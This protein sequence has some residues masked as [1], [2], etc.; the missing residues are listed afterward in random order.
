MDKS[1]LVDCVSRIPWGVRSFV[2]LEKGGMEFD[3]GEVD[4]RGKRER[5]GKGGCMFHSFWLYWA[6]LILLTISLLDTISSPA[7]SPVAYSG[8]R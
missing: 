6:R 3:E 7:S 8:V 5:E 2:V 4:R 1:G